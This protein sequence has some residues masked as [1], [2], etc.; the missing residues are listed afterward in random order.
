MNSAMDNSAVE[1]HASRPNLVKR[2]LAASFLFFLVKGLL[3]LGAATLVVTGF[4]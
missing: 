4:L 2:I 1:Q 3:W